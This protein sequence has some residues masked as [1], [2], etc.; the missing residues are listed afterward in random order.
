MP[1]LVSLFFLNP[2]SVAFGL[3]SISFSIQFIIARNILNVWLMIIGV[4]QSA[5]FFEWY[6]YTAVRSWLKSRCPL[7]Y[8]LPDL[9]DTFRV[10][11]Y[12]TV[13]MNDRLRITASFFRQN[14][15]TRAYYLGIA[16]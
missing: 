5:H 7:D 4:R 10:A 6:F 8:I 2:K 3:A 11:S 1:S 14:S 13:L 9:Y 16:G 15:A 12:C